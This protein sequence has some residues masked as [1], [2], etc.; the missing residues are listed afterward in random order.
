MDQDNTEEKV[1]IVTKG[2]GLHS[3]SREETRSFSNFVNEI[4]V[5][6]KAELGVPF[7]YITP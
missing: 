6:S 7:P 5:S 1:S 3:Y 4:L 2:G